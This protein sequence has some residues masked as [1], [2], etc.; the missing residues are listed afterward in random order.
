MFRLLLEGSALLADG[1]SEQLPTRDI[2]TVLGSLPNAPERAQCALRLLLKHSGCTR[3]HL[4]L[5]ERDHLFTAA[6]IGAAP[7]DQL[8]TL[9]STHVTEHLG[10]LV[11]VTQLASEEPAD[12]QAD[13]AGHVP[14]LLHAQSD[15]AP[16]LVGLVTLAGSPSEARAPEAAFA[17]AIGQALWNA[18]DSV[19]RELVH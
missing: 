11:T 8:L 9:A 1:A 10:T 6:S 15:S 16:L 13:I 17:R 4:F 3:G 7:D 5:F 19:G 18:G 14:V 2:E 12:Q